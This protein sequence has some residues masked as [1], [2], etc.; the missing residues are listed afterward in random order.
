MDR[1]VLDLVLK[2]LPRLPDYIRTKLLEWAK[3]VEEKGLR[4]VRKRPSYHDEPLLGKRF[5]QRSIRL[6]RSYR[7]IYREEKNGAI[8]V[9]LIQEVHK[10]A[11]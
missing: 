4:E 11:Y 6:S 2:D 3:A 8:T 10:H 5:G 7:A 9:V 1:V